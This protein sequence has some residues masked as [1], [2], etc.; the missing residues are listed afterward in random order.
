MSRTKLLTTVSSQLENEIKILI[1]LSTSP[2]LQS[3]LI[4]FRFSALLSFSIYEISNCLIKFTVSFIK[5]F[6]K[7]W[8]SNSFNNNRWTL[9]EK[10]TWLHC[11]SQY[12]VLTVHWGWLD[13]ERTWEQWPGRGTEQRERST[14]CHQSSVLH[15]LTITTLLLLLML[16][17]VTTSVNLPNIISLPEL[18][19]SILN[20]YQNMKCRVCK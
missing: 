20:K 5:L 14:P 15:S 11:I 6:I 1:T 16:H 10:I 8:L 7:C 12:W 17:P 4:S 3:Q 2:C 13:Y 9:V 19:H 18:Q